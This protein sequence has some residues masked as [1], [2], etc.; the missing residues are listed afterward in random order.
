MVN[1]VTGGAGF[2]GSHLI[3]KLLLKGEQVICIDNVLTGSEENLNKWNS[4]PSFKFIKHDIISPIDIKANKIWHL[5]C[6]ASPFFFNKYPITISKTNYLG[7]LNMLEIASKYKS[8]FLMASSSSIYGESKSYPQVEE[9]YGEV[10]S[11]GS[12]SCYEEGKRVAESLC[13]DYQRIYKTDIRIAR[14]FNTYGPRMK[15]DDGRVIS[16]FIYQA[17]QNEALTIY[18][19]G[20]QTRSFCYI[21][22]L[23]E[24]LL[25]LMESNYNK[26]LNLGNDQELRILDLA[27][28]IKS[29]INPDLKLK[30]LPLPLDDPLRRKPS[31][32]KALIEINWKPNIKLEEGITRTIRYFQKI[33]N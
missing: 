6:P 22:D 30:F 14:I 26:P 19:N 12:R 29:K 17:I 23:I 11:Y 27:N 13:F 7:T 3:E 1:L 20:C 28:L 8:R 31:I 24:G 4:H 2:I 5:A 16:N 33:L 21:D 25:I 32:K 18:G 10:N 15:P 9:Y